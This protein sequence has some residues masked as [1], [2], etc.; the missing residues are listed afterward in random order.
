MINGICSWAEQ[1]II[2]VIIGTI[3]EMILPK[4]NIE[5]YIKTVIGIYILYT[6]IS[7]AIGFLTGK[8]LKL[9]YNDYQEYFNYT[10]EQNFYENQLNSQAGNTIE[11]TYKKELEKKIKIDI[12]DMGFKLNSISLEFD[13]NNAAIRNVVLSINKKEDNVQDNKII[14]N[15]IEIGYREDKKQENELTRQEI[16]K[17]KEKLKQDYGIDQEEITINSI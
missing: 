3:I 17:I 10:D 16:E 12:E 5:K 9:T 4:G 1:V 8:E 6:V 7:P 13:L 11:D 2:A 14:I 15:N